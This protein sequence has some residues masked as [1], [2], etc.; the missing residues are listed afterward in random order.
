[1]DL[2][3]APFEECYGRC[4]KQQREEWNDGY[5]LMPAIWWYQRMLS[6]WLSFCLC[7]YRLCE[8][9]KCSIIMVIQNT[10]RVQRGVQRGVQRELQRRLKTNM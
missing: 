5:Q 6:G 10:G 7:D 9:T 1:M 4:K 3:F 2:Y 8:T